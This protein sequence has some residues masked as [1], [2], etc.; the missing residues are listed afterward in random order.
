MTAQVLHKTVSCPRCDWHLKHVESDGPQCW[1]CYRCDGKFLVPKELAQEFGGKASPQQWVEDQFAA[2]S[3][4]KSLLHCPHDGEQL[5]AYTLVLTG[6]HLTLRHCDQCEG[7]WL[8][9]KESQTLGHLLT[10]RAN[11]LEKAKQALSADTGYLFQLFSIFPLGLY[12]SKRRRPFLVPLT[13]LLYTVLMVLTWLQLDFINAGSTLSLMVSSFF[14]GD[15][16]WAL[17]SFGT[18]PTGIVTFLSNAAF[19]YLLGHNIEDRYGQLGFLQI[20]L[21]SS[22]AAALGFLGFHPQ[23]GDALLAG[24]QYLVSGLLGAYV[25][26]FGGKRLWLSF[27]DHSFQIPFWSL[28]GV[29]VVWQ[30][31]SVI[32]SGI[33]A[34][35]ASHIASILIGLCLARIMKRT[36]TQRGRFNY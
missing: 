26:L 7:I 22:L 18:A 17:L 32:H 4:R 27:R 36:W 6:R 31:G 1:V 2:M 19:W 28:S 8:D 25:I 14:A 34:E 5:N 3:V 16:P 30:L 35:G 15:Q 13:L 29:W 20:S 24:P 10:L 33:P 12:Y 23:S 11:A 21:M 9:K